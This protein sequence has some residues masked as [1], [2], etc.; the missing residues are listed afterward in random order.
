[1]DKT[2][3]QSGELNSTGSFEQS[4][5][6]ILSD[7]STPQERIELLHKALIN[8][9][10]ENDEIKAR[11]F[12]GSELFN[13]GNDEEAISQYEQ[14]LKLAGNSVS[15][16]EDDTMALLFR[17][18]C[19]K[20]VL[21]AKKMKDERGPKEC[22]AFLES[23][24]ADL[25]DF[26]S[27]A[28]YVELAT[29]LAENRDVQKAIMY[30]SKATICRRVDPMD[31]KAENVAWDS[32]SQIAKTNKSGRVKMAGQAVFPTDVSPKKA[33]AQKKALEIIRGSITSQT[34]NKKNL[35]RYCIAGVI[36]VVLVIG[37]ILVAL[38]LSTS[39]PETDVSPVLSV[40]EKTEPPKSVEAPKPEETPE[41]V[42]APSTIISPAEQPRTR[43]RETAKTE[44]IEKRPKKPVPKISERATDR[45]SEPQRGKSFAPRSRDDL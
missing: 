36:L 32:L 42:P 20:Y 17:K 41:P 15:L 14:S 5:R 25:K 44:K 28:L 13:V 3:D 33:G 4:L 27:P 21:I 9:L 40:P 43:P 45:P 16:F 19:R 34:R 22:L 18:L 29:L 8:G 1:M 39:K 24:A 23:K 37:A 10:P 6:V 35:A 38:Y 12:L 26:S 11:A 7:Q 2:V 31:R 30:F